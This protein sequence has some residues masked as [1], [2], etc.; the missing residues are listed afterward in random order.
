M[1]CLPYVDLST[2]TP[3]WVKTD[4]FYSN[5]DQ[6]DFVYYR[7]A[8]K[9]KQA[10]LTD[11]FFKNDQGNTCF[12]LPVVQFIYGATQFINGR[13]RIGVLIEHLSELPIAFA[14][15]MNGDNSQML[16]VADRPLDIQK[17]IWLPDLDQFD[18][19]N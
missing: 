13:H 9:V 8:K 7:E 1:N 16:K 17:P 6:R 11:W 3:F 15:S 10:Y 5:F 18:E 19:L 4:S 2:D 14:Q 12:K